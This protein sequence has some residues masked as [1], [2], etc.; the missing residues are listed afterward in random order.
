MK[1][2]FGLI[3]PE[4]CS[5]LREVRAG[6]PAGQELEETMKSATYWLAP[7]LMASHFSYCSP[8]SPA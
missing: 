3:C 8:D 6:T 5:S 2:G 4:Q 1:V 7:R